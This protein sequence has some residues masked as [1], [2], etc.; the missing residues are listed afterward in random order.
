MKTLIAD[1]FQAVSDALT[2][3]LLEGSQVGYNEHVQAEVSSITLRKSSGDAPILVTAR[4]AYH[5]T[6]QPR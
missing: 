1:A 3:P 4:I 6:I 5:L 2:R